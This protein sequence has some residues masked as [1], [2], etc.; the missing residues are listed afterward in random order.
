[1]DHIIRR[2]VP[3]VEVDV[4]LDACHASPVGGHHSGVRTTSKVLQSCYYWT[5]F[6]YDLHS[7]VTCVVNAKNKVEFCEGK[8]YLS[9][10][11]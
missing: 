1:M 5:T 9:L 4:I 2:R 10:L 11:F 8:N 7:L 6:S 3:E